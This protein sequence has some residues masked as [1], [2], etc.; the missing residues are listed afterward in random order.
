MNSLEDEAYDI[1]GVLCINY[2]KID[3]ALIYILMIDSLSF[4]LSIRQN[5]GISFIG[6]FI[7]FYI[8]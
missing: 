5:G 7:L 6:Y 1:L 3:E 2:F 4:S 8:C